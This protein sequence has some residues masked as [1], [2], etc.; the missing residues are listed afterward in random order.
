MLE[1]LNRGDLVM[2]TENEQ[3]VYDILNELGVV[4]TRYEHEAVFT[5]ENANR[6][7]VKIPGKHVKN[8]F[9]RNKKGDTHYL[10]ILDDLKRADIKNIA[11]Q[12]GTSPLSFASE[13][14]LNKYL[15][16]KSGYVSPLGLINDEEK[17]TK[18]LLD[19]DI[20]DSNLIGFHPN[21]N[22]ATV[23]ISYKDFEKF[24]KWCG[25]EVIYISI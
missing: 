5:V 16:L 17:K 24:I 10:V 3:R 22:T 18:L 1:A 15:G 11:L 2:I 20:I 12:I 21:I 8:L 19:K 14:R 23:T 6:L 7:D 13:E 9:L 25:N 4:Y